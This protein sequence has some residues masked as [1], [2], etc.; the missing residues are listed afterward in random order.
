MLTLRRG[1]IST[2]AGRRLLSRMLCGGLSL[3]LLAP[4]SGAASL[5]PA[6]E[7]KPL[8]SH[9]LRNEYLK[10][11]SRA[12]AERTIVGESQLEREEQTRWLKGQAA[13]GSL[14]ALPPA[15]RRVW[16]G[17]PITSVH[18]RLGK[19]AAFEANGVE[20]YPGLVL[21]FD[22]GLVSSYECETAFFQGPAGLQVGMALREVLRRLPDADGIFHQ[23]LPN[24]TES[25][26][27][28][29]M[30]D[31]VVVHL[32]KNEKNWE[33]SGVSGMTGTAVAQYY[34]E[35]K[36]GG[37]VRR[38]APDYLFSLESRNRPLP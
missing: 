10:R 37:G 8:Q 15:K 3:L 7:V 25:L 24:A 6:D 4:S 30:A 5:D 16:L 13:S 19:P 20:R 27:V 38:V 18:R 31:G 12:Q 32:Q 9:A 1:K 14:E 23:R 11:L 33:A 29:A 22:S 26:H 28:L 35:L 36:R 17:E 2:S 21:R 34:A